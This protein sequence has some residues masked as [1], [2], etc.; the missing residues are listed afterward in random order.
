MDLS[1]KDEPKP[2]SSSVG[3]IAIT[4]VTSGTRLRGGRKASLREKRTLK[5]HEEVASLLPLGLL[6]PQAAV[7]DSVGRRMGVFSSAGKKVGRGREHKL[8]RWDVPQVSEGMRLRSSCMWEHGDGV[9]GGGCDR[10][11]GKPGPRGKGCVRW[12]RVG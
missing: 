1:G 8:G 2:C 4:S 3:D 5:L 12:D 11:V 7:Q 9:S 6:H 10:R